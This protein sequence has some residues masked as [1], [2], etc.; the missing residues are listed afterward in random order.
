MSWWRHFCLLLASPSALDVD[1][2]SNRHW[3]FSNVHNFP[4]LTHICKGSPIEDTAIAKEVVEFIRAVALRG[5]SGRVGDILGGHIAS[6][7]EGGGVPR[8]EFL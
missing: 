8:T 6:A 7:G 2:I 3:S 4:P 5:W 1:K